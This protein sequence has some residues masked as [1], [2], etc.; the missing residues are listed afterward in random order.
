MFHDTEFPI[1]VG[2]FLVAHRVNKKL[3]QVVDGAQCGPPGRSIMGDAASTNVS[4][5][6]TKKDL[7]YCHK[8]ILRLA[9]LALKDVFS[10]TYP[11]PVHCQMYTEPSG[12]GGHT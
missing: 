7:E 9:E 4:S 5:R 12:Y 11:P 2:C 8:F 10:Y 1:V 6:S 3:A